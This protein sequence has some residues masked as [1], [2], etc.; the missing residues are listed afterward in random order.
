VDTTEPVS[1]R[2]SARED[3]GNISVTVKNIGTLCPRIARVNVCQQ[4]AL[5]NFDP[6]N[7]SQILP[8]V[9]DDTVA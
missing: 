8:I 6:Y 4:D 2:I 9:F 5:F 1:L 7:D 3:I